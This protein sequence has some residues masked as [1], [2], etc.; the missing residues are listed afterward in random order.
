MVLIIKISLYW[1]PSK[2]GYGP[3]RESLS[4]LLCATSLFLPHAP[5]PPLFLPRASPS[6]ACGVHQM[7]WRARRCHMPESH[8]DPRHLNWKIDRTPRQPIRTLIYAHWNRVLN[9]AFQVF[10]IK[11]NHN[12]QSTIYI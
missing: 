1:P 5:F 10:C 11:L 8:G 2:P 9:H 3:A 4:F 6:R 7:P 12:R